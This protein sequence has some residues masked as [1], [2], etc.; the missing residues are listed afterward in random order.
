MR[1]FSH[2]ESTRH[3]DVTDSDLFSDVVAQQVLDTGT[4]T[5]VLSNFKKLGTK[6]GEIREQDFHAE[7]IRAVVQKAWEKM[8]PV[9]PDFWTREETSTP[10]CIFVQCLLCG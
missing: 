10:Y 4:A 6:A 5:G 8:K 7:N 9:D 1:N 2:D 3:D